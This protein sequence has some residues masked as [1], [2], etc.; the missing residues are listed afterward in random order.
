ML[1]DSNEEKAPLLARRRL[2]LAVLGGVVGSSMLAACEPDDG[3]T[4]GDAAGTPRGDLAHRQQKL[5]GAP[6]VI[7]AADYLGTL[8]G[9]D[10]TTQLQA[11]FAA[12]S[13]GQTEIIF[14]GG[15]IE[16]SA[17]LTV[18]PSV[19]LIG[20][21]VRGDNYGVGAPAGHK[22]T[23][24]FWRGNSTDPMFVLSRSQEIR[25]LHFLVRPGYTCREAFAFTAGTGYVASS[26]LIADCG[27]WGRGT[28]STI[29]GRSVQGD[30]SILANGSQQS[31]SFTYGIVLSEGASANGDFFSVRDSSLWNIE[32]RSIWLAGGQPYHS[33][34][35][36]VSFYNADVAVLRGYT[37]SGTAIFCSAPGASVILDRPSFSRL[38][39]AVTV[40]DISFVSI[41]D[42]DAE[43]LKKLIDNSYTG[44]HN[45]KTVFDV[46]GG[47]YDFHPG[48]ATANYAAS[49]R[50]VI[51]HG[52]GGTFRVNTFAQS[53]DG[54]ATLK[55]RI[56]YRST[57]HLAGFWDDRDPVVRL[58]RLGGGSGGTFIQACG[59]LPAEDSLGYVSR[60]FF[61]DG[62]EN[63][64]PELIFAGATTT[65][66][67]TFSKPEVA[68]NYSV[69]P[70]AHIEGGSPAS[71]SLTA[72]ITSKTVNGF[73]VTLASAPGTGNS[74]RVH[75]KLILGA[76]F[77]EAITVT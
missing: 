60:P 71:G 42:A 36:D 29:W 43:Y 68:A 67:V 46:S 45:A 24:F 74:V 5:V 52:M 17:S 73:R 58:A 32:E 53:A 28:G 44:Y 63:A 40:A 7:D 23:R 48:L 19:R 72:S 37:M 1:E 33:V 25:G 20:G 3:S 27:I 65:Y 51:D 56:G 39:A 21:A 2:A 50:H 47:R 31:G 35:Q 69:L 61:R 4:T 26:V 75:C 9:T 55:I 15:D 70:V 13:P 30:G 11:L 16:I 62:C 66:L 64:D 57:L 14:P 54:G 12:C 76:P 59:G 8:N 10:K 22:P 38:E 41:R 6:R 34:C 18:P 77:N 49:D